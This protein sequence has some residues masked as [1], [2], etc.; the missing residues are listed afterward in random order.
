MEMRPHGTL[1][2]SA[3]Q[4]AVGADLVE[5]TRQRHRHQRGVE[6]VQLGA[7]SAGGV[8]GAGVLRQPG[9]QARLRKQVQVVR[10]RCG[11]AGFL[12]LSQHLVVGED[13]AGVVAGQLHQAAHERGFLDAGQGDDVLLDAGGDNRVRHMG[14]PQVDV[15][16]QR[17]RARVSPEEQ[18]LIEGVAEGVGHL[19]EG[20]VA[21]LDRHEA[22]GE[23]AQTGPH[24]PGC[25]SRHDH[26]QRTARSPI[27]VPL[28][29]DDQRPVL[30]VL[31]FVEG[32]DEPPLAFLRIPAGSSPGVQQPDAL[33][34]GIPQ[35]LVGRHDL[36]DGQVLAG[37][38]DP[39]ERLLDHRGLA[40]LT[41]TRDGHDQRL[42]VL[43]HLEDQLVHLGATIGMHG[44]KCNSMGW[45]G[46][47]SYMFGTHVSR[48][49]HSRRWWWC[50]RADS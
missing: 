3:P 6:D 23:V 50:P 28:T 11:V 47:M 5:R 4:G 40:G 19:G 15:V 24:R 22:P 34:A 36:V 42:V 37:Q 44:M 12:D 33:T 2:D 18:I 32:E 8:R 29:L 26:P 21:N 25:G 41:R 45:Y 49:D 38:V 35:A 30:D 17:S 14:P 9:E 20:P 43:H 27:A 7:R 1:D 16:H 39:L 48:V 13:L 31:D 46:S 10:E